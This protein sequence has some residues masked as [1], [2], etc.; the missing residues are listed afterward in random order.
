VPFNVN[1]EGLMSSKKFVLVL[2]AVMVVLAIAVAGVGNL[3]DNRAES[4]KRGKYLVDLGGCNLCHTPKI[5]TSSG[6]EL[7]ESRL[8]SGHPQDDA[9]SEYTAEALNAE[10]QVTKSNFHLTRWAGPWGVSF[11][12]NLTPDKITGIG[13]WSEDDFI[14]TIRTGRH[15]GNGREIQLPMPVDIFGQFTDDDLR[16]IFAYLK[17]LNPVENR[18]PASIPAPSEEEKGSDK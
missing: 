8:L 7:D 5:M 15:M 1:V 6:M 11:A 10:G 12:A 4:I 13:S 3:R 14:K 17:S 18:V 2:L 9:D 16:A